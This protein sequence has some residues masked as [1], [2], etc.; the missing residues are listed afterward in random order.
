MKAGCFADSSA[1][2]ALTNVKDTHHAQAAAAWKRLRAE[3]TRIVT[4]NYVMLEATFVLTSRGGVRLAAALRDAM[5]ASDRVVIEWVTPERH[6]SAWIEFAKYEDQG[7]SFVDAS[8]FGLMR[9]LTIRSAW[10][11]DADFSR[12]GF[13]LLA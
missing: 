11:Y 2:I 4:S 8:S 13:E 10:S 5:R 12:A 9:E 3:N 6:E 1:W 7:I